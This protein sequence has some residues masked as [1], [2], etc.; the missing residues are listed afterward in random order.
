MKK[1]LLAALAILAAVVMPTLAH[2]GV[3]T[4]YANLNGWQVERFDPTNDS[5]GGCVATAGFNNGENVGLMQ[6]ADKQWIL[7]LGPF[8]TLREGSSYRVDLQITSPHSNYRYVLTFSLNDRLLTAPV[9]KD[10]VNELAADPGVY[11][12]LGYVVPGTLAHG[13]V[14]FDNSAE[15]IRAVVHCR[16]AVQMAVAP[17]EAAPK[18]Q[19]SSKSYS[20]SGF[21]VDSKLILTNNHVIDACGD[22]F[23]RYPGQRLAPAYVV[24]RD[25]TNDLALLKTE[26]NN[27]GVAS[28][29]TGTRV[30]QQVATYGFPLSGILSSSGNFSIGNIASLA[31]FKDDTRALQASVPIQP[32]NSGG[33]LMNMSGAVIGV[34]EAE[35][36]ATAMIAAT[37]AVPQ[38]VNFAIQ[39]PIVLNFLNVKGVKPILANDAERL[40]PADVAEIAKR[41]TVQVL[42]G[43]VAADSQ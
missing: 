19:E 23:V 41:F 6:R 17:A 40:D 16:E 10:L 21:F 22:A 12:G 18:Q 33:P 36:R 29:A 8:K 25:K 20:G 15:V 7:A 28:F 4:Y 35:L 37:D 43:D 31:G 9:S 2:A 42:C 5:V 1:K 3:G 24:S 14:R 27:I 39:S 32:G 26:M 38:G 11:I 13:S 34:M 30:G